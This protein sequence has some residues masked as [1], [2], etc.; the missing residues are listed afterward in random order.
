MSER[1]LEVCVDS[2]ESAQ[3]AKAGGADRLELCANLVIGGTTPSLSLYRAVKRETGLRVHVLLRP[4]FGDFLYTKQEFSLL[5][6][7]AKRFLEEGAQGV[8]CGCLNP[9]GG[10]DE[11]RL[12]EL[13]SLSHRYKASFTLHRAFDVCQDPFEALKLCESMGVDRIL[14][15]GQAETCLKGVSLLKKLME[16][17]EKVPLLLGGGVD[18]QSLRPLLRKLPEAKEFHMSGKR[19]VQSGMKYR[20]PAVSMGLPSLSEYEIFRTDREKIRAAKEVLS[21]GIL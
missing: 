6:E 1:I 4:R 3:E 15:S 13:L 7:E 19:I 16:K 5:L 21:S 12:F 9:D 10:L 2:V 20:N 14:T 17:A 18:A 11:E 8:V